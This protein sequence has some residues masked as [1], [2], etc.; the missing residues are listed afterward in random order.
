MNENIKTFL[1]VLHEYGYLYLARDP[2]DHNLYAY[3][4]KPHLEDGCYMLSEVEMEQGFSRFLITPGSVETFINDYDIE[5]L[6]EADP[7]EISNMPVQAIDE[8]VLIETLI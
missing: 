1:N 2:D 4:S 8:P 6:Y 3:K 5:K 7:N